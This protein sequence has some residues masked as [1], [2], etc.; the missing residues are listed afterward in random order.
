MP[1]LRIPVGRP[2]GRSPVD[3]LWRPKEFALPHGDVGKFIILV[4]EHE[5]HQVGQGD[6]QTFQRRLVSSMR[7][8]LGEALP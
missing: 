2:R 5:W 1:E 6:D 4:E 8:P 3:L 7:L